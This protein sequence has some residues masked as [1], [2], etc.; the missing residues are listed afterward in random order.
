[1]GIVLFSRLHP[2]PQ[3]HQSVATVAGEIRHAIY[4]G[5]GVND[6]SL[7]AGVLFGAAMPPRGHTRRLAQRA[8]ASIALAMV[9]SKGS[10]RLCCG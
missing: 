7:L 1:M 3:A 10:D 9:I 2:N 4:A 6:G 8:P 5:H